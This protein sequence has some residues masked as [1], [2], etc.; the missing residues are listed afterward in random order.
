MM[1][2]AVAV[3]SSIVLLPCSFSGKLLVLLLLHFPRDRQ[4]DRQIDAM[5]FPHATKIGVIHFQISRPPGKRE[6]DSEKILYAIYVW[7]RK[8]VSRTS[9]VIVVGW[10]RIMH[11][12]G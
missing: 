8:L 10:V 1:P 2:R 9:C 3:G 5:E 6:H 11:K 4:T 12:L 7:D